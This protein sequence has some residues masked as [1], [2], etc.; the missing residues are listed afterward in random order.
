[1]TPVTRGR[2]GT[3]RV[4]LWWALPG[5]AVAGTAVGMAVV[6]GPTLGEHV[7][8]PSRLVL[9]TTA[10]AAAQ[11]PVAQTP[12]SQRP[13]KSRHHPTPP[14]TATATSAV[15]QTHV[16]TPQRPLVT[17]SSDDSHETDAGRDRS[18]VDIQGTDR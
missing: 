2:W 7:T 5:L 10:P 4:R 14:P 3:P 18:G 13:A 8:I 1:M 12:T 6:V 15:P 9:P 17:A 16:V 11:T